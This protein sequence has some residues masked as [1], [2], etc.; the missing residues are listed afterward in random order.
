[1]AKVVTVEI[2]GLEELEQ[3]LYDLRTKYA[4]RVMRRALKSA[5]IWLEE[6]KANSRVLTGWMKSQ[7]K[8]VIRLSARE[9]SGTAMVG[10]TK[11]QNPQRHAKHVPSAADEAYWLELGTVK[12]AAQ[13]FMR[14]AFDSKASAVLAEFEA[15]A[16]E[17]L[18][19]FTQ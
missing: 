4:K 12:E 9:E 10:F 11:E 18:D 1:V 5:N 19:N 7:A 3:K 14:P 8:M 17:E 6:I 13:P 15:I 16:K 2:K